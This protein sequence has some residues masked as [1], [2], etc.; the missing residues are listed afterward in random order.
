MSPQAVLFDMDGLMLDSEG[1]YQEAWQVAADELGYT[2]ADD[3]YLSLVGRSNAEAAATFVDVFGPDFPIADFNNRW[4]THWQELVRA[5]GVSLKPGLLGL[6]DWLEAQTVPKA[7]G[8]SSNAAEAHLC[9]SVAGIRDRF[10]TLVTVDQVNAGKPAPDIFLEAAH[11]LGVR[12]ADCL[13]LEDSNAGVQAAHSAGI[14][15]VMVPDLQTP[16]D[17]SKAIALAI[18]PSLHAVKTWLTPRIG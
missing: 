5:K 13:V 4:H 10:A 3:V 18:L 8:T 17:A 6:L 9:L 14:P 2:L 7:V 16:T 11:R 12:P 1:L 15:V